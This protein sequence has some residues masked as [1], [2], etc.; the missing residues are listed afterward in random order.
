MQDIMAPK[1]TKVLVPKVHINGKFNIRIEGNI[2][3][4]C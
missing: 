1:A 2:K 3:N 4:Q